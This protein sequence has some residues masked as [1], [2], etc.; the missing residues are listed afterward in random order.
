M[1]VRPA[2]SIPAGFITPCLAISAPQPPSGTEWVHEVKHD[3]IR[4]IARKTENGVR[5]YSG[6]AND[7]TQRFPVI[8][9]AVARLRATSC[10]I[11]G[12]AVV[13][14]Q[15]GIA[16]FDLLRYRRNDF[17]A[18]MWAFDLIEM[19]GDD[20]RREPLEKRKEMLARVLARANAGLRLNDH[21]EHANGPHVFE[22]AC[23]MGLEG[24]VSKRKGSPYR[25]G[26]TLDWMKAANPNAPAVMRRVQE[27]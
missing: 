20:L 1:L 8:A 3:G 25:A 21:L 18:F 14:G 7:L 6:A 5:L 22:H 27:S 26:R 12:E 23:R 17:S 2:S 24:I 4:L 9:E 16:V 11:D 19:D 10:I 15:D 13:C